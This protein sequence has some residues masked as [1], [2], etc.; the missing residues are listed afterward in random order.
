MRC[1]HLASVHVE[2]HPLSLIPRQEL[3]RR[4][5]Q[6]TAL[7]AVLAALVVAVALAG[8]VPN[9]SA[10]AN[11]NGTWQTLP[12]TM[13][14]NP[15]H[16]A[17]M[18]TGK[19]LVVSGSGNYP[20]DTSYMAAI[21]DPATDTVTTMPVAWD[22][23]C[24][25]MVVM[26]DG[27][28][29]VMGGTLQYDPFYGHQKTSAFN[30]TTG[31]FADQQSMAD[32]R[33]YPTGLVLG[34]GRVMVF[35]GLGLT[36]NT[37]TTVEFYTMGKGWSQPYNAPWTPP[38]YPRLHLLPNGNVF[39]S[40]SST[41]SALF[42]PSNETWTQNVA[43]TIYSG[44]RTYGS[45]VLMPLTPANGFKPRVMIFG[46]GSPATTTTE[47]ID[48]S[49]AN[50]KWASGVAMSQARIEM[51]ATLLPSGQ[52]L[53][54][55]GS[56]NDEDASTESLNADI[57]DS[58]SGARSSG[59]ANAF[60]R[61][62]HSNSILL[63]DA[64]VLLIGGNPTRGTY[65]SH[66]EIYTPAYLY[67]S[68]GQLATRPT[69]SSVSSS[70]LGYNAGFTITTPNASS[71]SSVVLMRAGAVTHAFDMD[72]RMV[73]LSFTAGSGVLN[74]TTPTNGN[75]APPGY[76]LLFILNSSGVPSV[77]QF[78]QLMTTPGTPPT[79]TITSPSSD[80]TIAAGQSVSFA[81]TGNAPGGSI[82]SYDWVFPGG[83]PSTS[84][85]ASPGNVTF[86]TAG[87]YVASLTVTDN[88]G[89]TDPNPPTRTI[90][91]VPAFSLSASPASQTV[92]AGSATSF[93]VTVTPGSGFS[94]TVSFSSS[95][96]P[97]GVTATFNPTTVTTSGSTTLNISTTSAVA[98]GTYPLTIT[99][100]SNGLTENTAVSL[101]VTG[102]T[103][104]FTITASPTSI[105]VARGSSGKSTITTTISGGF[106]SA[107]TLTASGEGSA[108]TVTF[109]PSSIAAP[110]SGTSTMTVKVGNRA[111]LGNHKITITAKG[112]GLTHTTT[113]TLDV[114]K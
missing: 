44:T 12:T 57:Y 31:T 91:V 22:M 7:Q 64:T 70:V 17:L 51:N 110:G 75:L 84:S 42:N 76:Y 43:S 32:G 77:A 45:S 27:R 40:G 4:G 106:N 14:I 92:A 36:G 65:E 102:T 10:Q 24:N 94:G 63:P 96:A 72:Q 89:R 33:W 78:V 95:G 104:N 18:H 19:I 80:V 62:Y 99:G 20:P 39:Y 59:G 82:A 67:N 56:V 100:T 29:F 26:P 1:P 30:P 2:L 74:A 85:A 23:F 11:V 13:P 58:V 71:I 98:A 73:G 60:A 103:P 111:A 88:S 34:D 61:L 46:G 81:G 41:N 93:S 113:V 53:A 90:T 16:I 21:W 38:L 48:L 101:T 35:S 68:S 28:P 47:V 52:I 55:G 86:A 79:G 112:G 49:V 54:T 25:G 83:S 109:S 97:S 5:A 66:M 108:Q 107:I 3:K 8:M 15:V 87:T 37:N 114:L 50:P 69:I 6:R 9:A 105:S